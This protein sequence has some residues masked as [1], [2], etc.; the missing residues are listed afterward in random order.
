MTLKDFL[1]TVTNDDILVTLVDSEGDSLIKF[2]SE[3]FASVESDI[4]AMTVKKTTIT[5]ATALTIKVVETSAGANSDPSGNSDP[6]D[7]S[8]P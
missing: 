3:G 5:G 2:Y 4:L 7:P 8:D 6:T 1:E